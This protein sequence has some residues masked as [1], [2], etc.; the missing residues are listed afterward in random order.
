AGSLA[1]LLQTLNDW[2]QHSQSVHT[3]QAWCDHARWL[4]A[5]MFKPA[6]EADTLALA[7]LHDALPT[8]QRACEQAGLTLSVGLAALQQGWMDALQEPSLNQR[9]RAGGV[10]FCTLEPA[11]QSRWCDFLHPHAHACHPV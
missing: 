2:W 10:T 3:P 6:D 11:I 1:H 7:A 8:W 5:S 4:L 9:F